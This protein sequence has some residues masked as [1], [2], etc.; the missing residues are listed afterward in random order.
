MIT[1]AIASGGVLS[2][3]T[4]NSHFNNQDSTIGGLVGFNQGAIKNAI[5]LG[6]VTATFA[7]SVSGPGSSYMDQVAGLVANNVGSISNSS[8]WGAVSL[9]STVTLID[10]GTSAKMAGGL[11]GTSGPYFGSIASSNE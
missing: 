3:L 10:G 9:T 5:A 8:S 11:A 1:N 4:Y 7:G 2:N 6:A